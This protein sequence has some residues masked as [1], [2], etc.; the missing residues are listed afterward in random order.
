MQPRQNIIEIF[1]TF[2]QFTADHFSYW[3]TESSLRR[4]IQSCFNRYRQE[5]TSDFWVLYWYKFWQVPETQ[6]LAQQHLTAYLQ[7]TCYWVS[8][9][10]VASFTSTQY[11]LSDCFQI[12]IFKIDKILKNFEPSLG[13]S[14]KNYA[15]SIFGGAIR[16]TLRQRQEVDICSDWGLL[17][18]TTKKRLVESL[19]TAGLSPEEMA[20]YLLAV[21][22]FQTLYVPTINGSSR[23]LVRPD[24]RIWQAIT[25][26]YCSQIGQP[27]NPKTLENWLLNAAIA[28]RKYLYPTLNSL[29]APKGQDDTSEWMD[30]LPGVEIE[31]L[32]DEIIAQEELQTRISQQTTINQIL[33]G[34]I[35]QLEPQLQQILHLYY[36]QE[37]TQ[38]KIAKQLQMQQY[39]V[40]RRLNKAREAILLSLA[41][42]SGE[43]LHISITSDLLKN[44]STVMEEWLKNHY[45]QT[46][47]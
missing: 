7:E 2:I 40:S 38:D 20:S 44:I 28:V 3:A 11:Q 1:S 39:T 6:S 9:K 33:I 14:L 34:A 47:A 45:S 10:T 41:K 26:A 22:C 8:Q 17:R 42:W 5:T 35:A 30:N 24:E 23:Q 27:A 25:T 4:S 37:L 19:Q 31:S 32:V 13:F 12:A 43:I 15:S 21:N 29:N 16:E 46:P 18:K 36:G